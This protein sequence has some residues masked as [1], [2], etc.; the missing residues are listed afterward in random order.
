MINQ[1]VVTFFLNW[2]S[3][4]SDQ[5]GFSYV[6]VHMQK[7]SQFYMPMK[8]SVRNSTI[9]VCCINVHLGTLL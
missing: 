6:N 7:Q 3:Y 8:I 2:G 4:D 5:T 9:M 1:F